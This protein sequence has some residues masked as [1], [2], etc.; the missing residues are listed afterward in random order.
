MNKKIFLDTLQAGLNGFGEEEKREILY[1]YE[2]HFRIGT[3]HGKSEEEICASLG[4]P[5]Q[6]AMA[7][8]LENVI[9]KAEENPRPFNLFLAILAAIGLGLFNL[10]VVLGIYLALLGA[11]F[12]FFAASAA[13]ILSGI[14]LMGLPFLAAESMFFSTIYN[15]DN[16]IGK[17]ACFFSGLGLFSLGL[18][19]LILSALLA[20]LLGHLTLSYIKANVSLVKKAGTP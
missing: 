7:Y 6:I 18:F 16:V 9:K 10:I 13:V 5:K 12:G 2:E 1:D 20:K 8:R 15:F 17:I 3:E 19:L 11:L 14:V 4:S